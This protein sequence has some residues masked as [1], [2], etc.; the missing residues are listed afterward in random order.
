M[1][2]AKFLAVFFLLNVIAIK[3]QTLEQKA[4]NKI[5][6]L[7]TLIEQAENEDID[8]LKEKLTIR[9][10]EIFLEYANW[11][12]AN[13]AMNTDLFALV[14][15]YKNNAAEMA[16]LL[17]NFERNDVIKMLDDAITYINLLL[18]K[19]VFRK[20]IPKI[21]W[22]E[23]THEKDQLIFNENPVFLS[24][25][26]W[27]PK[28]SQLTEFHG[29]LDGFFIS[30]NMV[31]DKNGTIKSN[32]I[33]S[34]NAKPNG[35]MGFVFLN[36]KSVSNWT[37]TAYGADFKM[38]TDTFTAYDIDNPGAR[39]MQSF[40]L[41]GTVPKMAG[42]KYTELGYMLVN[43]P[44][45]FT[46]TS[47]GN[48]PWASGGVSNFTINKFKNWL[49]NK[50]N[51]IN[52]LNNLWGTNFSDFDNVSIT[53][54]IHTNKRGTAIWYDWNLF[55]MDRVTDWYTF[56]KS[57]IRKYDVDAKVHLKI[58]PQL[59]TENERVHGI[60]FEALTD[61]SE[62]V[63]NDAQA[64][65]NYMWGP[66]PEWEDH[67]A[68]NWRELCM[69]YDFLKSVSPE[70]I[71]FNS[72]SHFL[73]TG[74]SRDLY[75][76]P[77]YA[78]AAYW[79]AHTYGM[80]ANQTWFWA[81]REDGSPRNGLS[82]GNGYAGSNNHQP[83]IINEVESTI[84][85]LNSFSDEIMAL[86]R[87]R[88]PIRIFYSKTSA[89]NKENHMDDVFELY[90]S[91][92][93]DGISLG[94]ATKN[95]IEK[96]DNSLWDVVIIY[97]TE[98]VTQDEFAALQTYLDNGGTIILDSESLQKNEYGQSLSTLNASN[99]AIISNAGLASIK[100]SAFSIL[101]QKN[102][103]PEITVTET[104]NAGSKGCVWKIAKNKAGNNVLSIVNLGKT[105]A[106]LSIN[107]KNV[108]GNTIT[109]DLIK[110]IEVSNTPTLK[111]YEV[112][113]VE[114]TDS[115]SLSVDEIATEIFNVF[116][117]PANSVLNIQAE[118]GTEIQMYSVTGS[119]IKAFKTVK[120][121][122]TISTK[123]ISSGIYL[124]KMSNNKKSET[125]K[126]IINDK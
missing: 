65:N 108:L 121:I 52:R 28:T 66:K 68:L 99:G 102:S 103:F 73:S 104:N 48:L 42:K 57:E 113:F 76:D 75:M 54:P 124:V 33:S 23:V 27:K 18:Q 94:F 62:I 90:E 41:A 119:K 88:K 24:D 77:A 4:R 45:F 21:N 86:Q 107:L 81:R 9:T 43:E 32:I 100:L 2:L 98:F 37:E 40:L 51:N 26:T 56:L 114:V 6:A 39:E 20:P 116:P 16:N 97:K 17:P 15:R 1:K 60:D 31:T 78:R 29:N 3:A 120:N 13:I 85:D 101:N 115:N 55:N 35:S 14:S 89:I 61:L 74:K 5:I 10:A 30:P 110:G 126:I 12:E 64:V 105:D 82:V 69:S 44:H 34:L 91:L 36:H 49:A 8:V 111:P 53:I 93:F 70:K 59:W 58:M 46:H 22:E 38:R 106:N 50:H 109:K 123:N 80:T 117:N 19:K 25:Y 7:N 92:H 84:Q 63:G 67:Y 96:Q 87:Q 47:G 11:D 79:L 112:Y 122:T 72:E 83:R 118:I 95:I 71:N 125:K